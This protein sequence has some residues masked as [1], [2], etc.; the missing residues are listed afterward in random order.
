MGLIGS[1]ALPS[2]KIMKVVKM[3]WAC[4]SGG[5]VYYGQNSE[6]GLG[7]WLGCGLCTRNENDENGQNCENSE[8]G[9]GL[10]LWYGLCTHIQ[11][12]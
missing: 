10:R 1:G 6:N 2:V 7:L 4:G 3:V 11:K 5:A 9:L 8:N 12:W